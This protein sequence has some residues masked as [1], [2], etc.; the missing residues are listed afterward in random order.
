M[1]NGHSAREQTDTP[2]LRLPQPGSR[3]SL[4]PSDSPG[5]LRGENLATPPRVGLTCV[6]GQV[7]SSEWKATRS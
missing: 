4:R 5:R 3:S 1:T 2:D 6:G 7:G